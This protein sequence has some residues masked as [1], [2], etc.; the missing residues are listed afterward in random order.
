MRIL[1]HIHSFNDEDIIDRSLQALLEQTLPV[2]E[3][4]LVDN[5]STDGTLMR[6]FPKQ[7]TVIQHPENRGTSGAV[8]TG[9]Q[10][11]LAKEYDWIYIL[12]GDSVPRK[13]AL[14][15]LFELYRSF[16]SDL[17][18]QTWRL[19]S[20]PVE[21]P[22]QEPRHGIMFT[23]KGCEMV[24]PDPDRPFYECDSTIWSGS[25]YKLSAVRRVGLPNGDYVLDWGEY[26]YGYLGKLR[27][28][29]AF[30]HQ[31]SIIDHT[32]SDADLPAL[33]YRFGPLRL[34]VK[35]LKLPPIRLY[36]IFRNTLY[37]WLYVYHKG[38]IFRYLRQPSDSPN[39]LCLVKYVV[40][41]LLLSQN[42]W[43]DL[44]AC[45]RGTWDGLRRNLHRRY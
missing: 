43:V 33:R 10:H 36:Y 37:F 15:K 30:M 39:L 23:A 11:A 22:R 1:G 40:R 18:A 28:Y 27:G 7:V 32:V 25:L 12:D 6:P 29:R 20:L 2:D 14:E 41:V 44:R 34:E 21:A 8:I 26:E 3:I 24:K 5:A 35:Q 45:M 17:Q 31:Q 4:V 19:S 42:R 16:P 9:M 13:D 38:N